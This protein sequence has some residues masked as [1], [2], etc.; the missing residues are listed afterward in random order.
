MLY[1][2]RRLPDALSLVRLALSLLLPLALEWP[3]A[4]AALY[5]ACGLSDALDGLLARRWQVTSLLGA[6]LDSLG[7]AAFYLAAAWALLARAGWPGWMLAAAALVFGM[8]ALNLA[9]CRVRFGQWGSLHTRLNKAA[10]LAVF[11]L[12]PLGVLWPKALWSAAAA[13]GALALAAAL[14]ESWL[15][16]AMPAYAPDEAGLLGRPQWGGR[17][18]EGHEKRRE[19]HDGRRD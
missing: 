11:L 10:G 15:L 2:R 13:A 14:E 5:A 6:K 7:D 12:L 3:A 9:L 4:F 8:R 19:G 16:L 1:L 17:H 18:H